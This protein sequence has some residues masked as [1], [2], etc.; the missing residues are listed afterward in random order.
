MNTKE[1]SLVSA[2]LT[3][4]MRCLV[5]GDI[6]ALQHMQFGEKE[7]AALK[8]LSMLDLYR[9][10]SLKV[11]CLSISLNRQ[12]FW[13]MIEVLKK[14]REN[15]ETINKLIEEDAPLELMNELY[16]MNSREYT[17]RRRHFP[18][19]KGRGRPRLPDQASEDALY[20]QWRKIVNHRD[21]ADLTP[22]EYLQLHEILGITL[23][24]IWNLISRWRREEMRYE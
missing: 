5:E 11:H 23:R 17:A 14:Q 24:A 18:E 13:P 6:H 22:D 9:A 12:V 8:E 3:Y 10:E 21:S 2:T 16:G 19:K 20:S 4:A 1:G 7:V 15:D